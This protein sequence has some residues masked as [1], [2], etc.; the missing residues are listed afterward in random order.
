MSKQF[1]LDA[2]V[3]FPGGTIGNLSIVREATG[4]LPAQEI[5]VPAGKS[6]TLSTR[7][8]DTAGT[9]TLE[10]G[11]GITDGQTIDV[12]WVDSD[13]RARC[14]HGA[15]VGTVSGDDVPFTGAAGDVLPAQDYTIVADVEIPI[16]VD[17][18]ASKI[19]ALVA[20]CDQQYCVRFLTSVPAL[21][22]GRALLGREPYL[23]A[24]GLG[25]TAGLGSSVI[26]S[27]TVSSGSTSAGT[28]Q[29]GGTYN[30]DE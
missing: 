9:V 22:D 12:H 24:T 20:L 30:S 29:F 2:D 14:A 5:S 28:F 27:M 11:H 21:V 25:L 10:S 8:S 7:T 3:Q 19:E 6:G 13:G 4:G 23:Y 15:T 26:A 16:D 1:N 17:F 18:D